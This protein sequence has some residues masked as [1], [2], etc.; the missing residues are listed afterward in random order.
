[1]TICIL[2]KLVILSEIVAGI[3]HIS[4][5]HAQHLMKMCENEA[6]YYIAFNRL[7]STICFKQ[8]TIISAI[9]ISKI[10]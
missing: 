2:T 7:N 6:S 5:A 1:M 9:I 8:L 3:S 10:L 4:A